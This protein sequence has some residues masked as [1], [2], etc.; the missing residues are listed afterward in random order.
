MLWKGMEEATVFPQVILTAS[1]FSKRLFYEI[2]RSIAYET[3][4]MYVND[5]R[6]HLTVFSP[7]I[8]IFRDPR[9][10]RGHETPGEDPHL[11]GVYAEY[12][13]KG[14]QES[15]YTGEG[16]DAKERLQVSGCLKHF[17]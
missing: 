12:Y 9:W 7:N 4:R 17:F 10:G 1:S 8:N 15:N 2:G 14:L 3:K 6:A 13:L 11:N 16:I 5:K